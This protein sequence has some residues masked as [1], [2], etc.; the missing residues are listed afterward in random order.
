MVINLVPLHA[1]EKHFE[2]I[3]FGL[4]L[5]S[6][7]FGLWWLLPSASNALDPVYFWCR[8]VSIIFNV[9]VWCISYYQLQTPQMLEAE[10]HSVI[11]ALVSKIKYYPIVQ[12][13]T[14]AG[15]IW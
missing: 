6:A 13:I 3:Q 11:S 14:R 9:V 5:S 15:A 12:I 7:L 1:V 4:L 8:I 2:V 10:V